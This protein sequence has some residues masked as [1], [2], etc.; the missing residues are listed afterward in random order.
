MTPPDARPAIPWWKDAIVYQIYPRSSRVYVRLSNLRDACMVHR[1]IHLGLGWVA[2]FVSPTHFVQVRSQ[3]W[4]MFGRDPGLTTHKIVAPGSRYATPYEGQ[5]S[6][7]ALVRGNMAIDP[8]AIQTIVCQL[9]QGEGDLF[10]FQKEIGNDADTLRAVVE[11]SETTV[12]VNALTKYRNGLT[13]D[14]SVIVPGQLFK[15]RRV[16]VICRPSLN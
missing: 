8:A 12:A 6:L 14:V 1:N 16:L 2:S 15:L 9:L 4:L 3:A 5:L 10:A 7:L 13:I 11:F